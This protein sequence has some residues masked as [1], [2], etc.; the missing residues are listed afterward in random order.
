MKLII[1]IP[2]YNLVEVQNG[3]IACGQI[4][5]AGKNGKPY[6][7]RPQGEWQTRTDDDGVTYHFYCSCCGREVQVI[8]DYCPNCGADMRTNFARYR[9]EQLKNP[10]FKEEYEKCK[11]ELRDEIEKGEKND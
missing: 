5:K 6:A 11:K 7:E 9:D 3:S 4:L 8:T 2:N 10:I 1:D